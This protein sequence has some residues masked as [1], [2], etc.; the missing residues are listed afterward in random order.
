MAFQTSTLLPWRTVLRNVTLPLELRKVGKAEAK[1]RAT[2]LLTMVGLERF[3]GHYPRELSGGM[4]QR[5]AICRALVTDPP[6]LLMDEPFGALDAITR[7]ALNKEVFELSR[8]FGKTVVFVTH[9]IQEAARM[10]HR[11]VLLH[12]RPGKVASIIDVNLDPDDYANRLNSPDFGQLVG[13]FELAVE[14]ISAREE[15]A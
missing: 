9:D 8:R 3:L 12:P 2:E 5:A 1:E 6:I 4:R 14:S 7:A 13:E 15:N 10:G 11:V